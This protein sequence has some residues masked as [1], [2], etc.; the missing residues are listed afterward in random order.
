MRVDPADHEYCFIPVVVRLSCDGSMPDGAVLYEKECYTYPEAH[1]ALAEELSAG[2][3]AI[4][5]E[6]R[7]LYND[8]IPF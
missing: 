2:N 8:W 4:I 7:M 6:K 5:V 1:C 3:C